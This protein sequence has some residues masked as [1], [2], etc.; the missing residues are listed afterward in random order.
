MPTHHATPDAGDEQMELIVIATTLALSIGLGL[1]G[2][3]A[4]MST[5]FYVMERARRVDPGCETQ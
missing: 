3:Y 4:M 2:T 1:A 5:A